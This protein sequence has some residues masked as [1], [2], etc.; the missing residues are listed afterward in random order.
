MLDTT[1]MTTWEKELF[2]SEADVIRNHLVGGIRLRRAA[3]ILGVAD[4]EL[5]EIVDANLTATP[6]E[7]AAILL[8]LA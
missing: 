6:E 4:F 2:A 3:D 5:Q 8:S 7:I 1:K